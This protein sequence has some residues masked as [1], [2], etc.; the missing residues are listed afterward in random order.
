M[1]ENVGSDTNLYI[2][3]TMNYQGHHQYVDKGTV[4]NESWVSRFM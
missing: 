4:Y 3:L 2:I 1:K